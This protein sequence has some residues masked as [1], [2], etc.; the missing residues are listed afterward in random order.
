M[1]QSEARAK[2]PKEHLWWHGPN[3]CWDA[4]PPSRARLAQRNKT[5]EAKPVSRDAPAEREAAEEKKPS[6]WASD[7]R[8][9]DA[10]S[11][12]SPADLEG[13]TA[14]ARAQ[15][16]VDAVTASPAPRI[17]WRERW[18][19]ITQRM[20]AAA[21]RAGPADLAADASRTEPIVTPVRVMLALLVLLL[22]LGAFELMRRPARKSWGD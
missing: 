6:R 10:M 11:K 17:D 4:T 9:R 19:E 7:S 1:T 21:D 12:A 3:R 18:V 8:W 13:V 15:A 2:F 16:G 5:R 14:P 22:A 20:P